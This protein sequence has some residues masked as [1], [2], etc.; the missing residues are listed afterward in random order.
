LELKTQSEL[1]LLILEL[2]K[3]RKGE[4]GF[5][6]NNLESKERELS[7]ELDHLEDEIYSN[8]I[9][10]NEAVRAIFGYAEDRGDDKENRHV[11]AQRGHILIQDVF[12]EKTKEKLFN[13][14]KIDRFT[15]G[16]FNGALFNEL[17]I[18]TEEEILID[19]RINKKAFSEKKQFKEAFELA[20]EDL[21]RGNL[22]LG[23]GTTKGHGVFIEYNIQ[24]DETH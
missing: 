7:S 22:P 13:H 2:G 8:L 3:L 4:L 20:I 11:D 16:A 23:G 12:I 21:K 18:N 9:S 24:K 14:V 15:G 6:L 10:K 1:N 5:L 17:T 19:I